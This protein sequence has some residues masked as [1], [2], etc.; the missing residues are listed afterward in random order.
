MKGRIVAMGILSLIFMIAIGFLISH[1]FEVKTTFDEKTHTWIAHESYKNAG[2]VLIPGVII[3]LTALA[4]IVLGI[5][6]LASEKEPEKG[7]NIAAGVLAIIVI[8]INWII[9]LIA[10]IKLSGSNKKVQT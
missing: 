1:F 5:I 2:K 6:H 8:G 3:G 10:F 7:L 9:C 4:S